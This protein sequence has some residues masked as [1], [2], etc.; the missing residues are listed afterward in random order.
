MSAAPIA[1]FV[2][3][4]PWHTRQTVES[5]QKNEG[6]RDS[7]LI[8][9][10]DAPRDEFQYEKVREV[11]EYIRSIDGFKDVTII[12]RQK[13]LGLADSIISGVTEVVDQYGKIIVLE[14]DMISSPFFLSFVN[15]ALNLYKNEER[16]I[17]IHGYTHPVELP[18]P[19]TFVLKHTPCWGWATWKRGWDLFEP[20]GLKLL[21]KV[22]DNKL[23]KKFNINGTYNFTRMLEDQVKGKINSWAIRWQAAAFIN[24]KYT[25][26]PGRSLIKNI[27]H[28]SSG[29]HCG[30][31]NLFD[32]E[33]STSPINTYEIPL[34][35]ESDIVNAFEKYFKSIKY[36]RWKC[37]VNFMK[38]P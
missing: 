7:R 32:V 22:R 23:T 17:S 20:D 30:T 9:F 2:Y 24:G 11:R 26:F 4:R 18:L 27:G 14:D 25:L 35:E 13:N 16:L 1:L 33:L 12:E 34:H 31:S 21:N 38:N 15:K 36:S 10:S 29:T 19:E 6:A 28:D 3:N 5:L 8:V 37:L